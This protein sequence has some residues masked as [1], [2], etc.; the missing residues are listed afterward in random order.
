MGGAG[1][2]YNTGRSIANTLTPYL[3]LSERFMTGS[4]LSYKYYVPNGNYQVTLKFAEIYFTTANQRVM[5][6]SINGAQVETNFDVFTK[7][8]GAFTSFDKT[9]AVTVTNGQILLALAPALAGHTPK[10]SAIQI[11]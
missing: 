8:G 7:A 9:Y 6:I 11:Q 10:I 2:I 1:N 4:T 3:Y 5:N